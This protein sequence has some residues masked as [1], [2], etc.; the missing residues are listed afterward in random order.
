MV[1]SGGG[2][3][4]GTSALCGLRVFKKW[5]RYEISLVI[6]TQNFSL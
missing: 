1:K 2:G 6:L 3:A 5:C 4:G